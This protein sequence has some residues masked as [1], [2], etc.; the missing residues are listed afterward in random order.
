[1]KFKGII[2][3]LDGTVAD[4][5]ADLSNAINLMLESLGF[6]KKSQQEILK[7]INFGARAFVKGCLPDEKLLDEALKRYM[8]FYSE[9][10]FEQTRLYDGIAELI[11][12]LHVNNIKMCVLSNKPDIMTKKIVKGLLNKSYFIDILGGSERF[13]HKPKPDSA[14]YMAEK[15]GIA[16]DEILYIGDS[17]VDMKTAINAGMFPL[18]VTWGYRPESFIVEAGAKKIVHSPGEILD[19]VLE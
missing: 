5:G 13:P 12:S 7:H 15:M 9:H 19:F 3:D 17:D 16:P 8:K 4:T 1:M 11:E 18:G 2:F 10:C 6:E 14:L